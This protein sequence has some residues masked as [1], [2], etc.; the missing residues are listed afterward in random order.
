MNGFFAFRIA[1]DEVTLPWQVPTWQHGIAWGLVF[2]GITAGKEEMKMNDPLR[3]VNFL[4][5]TPTF[6]RLFFQKIF[7]EG[8]FNFNGLPPSLHPFLSLHPSNPSSIPPILPPSL[9]LVVF[10]WIFGWILIAYLKSIYPWL[11]TDRSGVD[12]EPEVGT[13]FV[14]SS[15]NLAGRGYDEI[16]LD[17]PGS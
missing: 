9:H 8:L 4:E 7:H 14:P 5:T 1:R 2:L 6:E 12:R 13:H 11:M 10:W 16:C 17:V 15:R 3:W